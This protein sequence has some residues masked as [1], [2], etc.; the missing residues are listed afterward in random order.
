MSHN[1]GPIYGPYG[2]ISFCECTAYENARTEH[3]KSVHRATDLAFAAGYGSDD[4]MD[5]RVPD[6][7]YEGK[8]SKKQRKRLTS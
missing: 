8:S 2:R 7:I 3:V 1:S 4:I 5:G 6:H